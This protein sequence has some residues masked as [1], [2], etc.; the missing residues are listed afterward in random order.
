M[1]SHRIYKLTRH[2][3]Y[4]AYAIFLGVPLFSCK[5][6]MKHFKKE[7]VGG[8]GCRLSNKSPKPPGTQLRRLPN[9]VTYAA[10]CLE[11][12]QSL[13]EGK[14]WLIAIRY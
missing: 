2:L 6:C 4:P 10:M 9:C 12:G 8:A 7:C 5:R 11:T 14:V 1:K 13:L 3:T